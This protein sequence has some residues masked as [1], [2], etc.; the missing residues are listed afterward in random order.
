MDGRG[1]QAPAHPGPHGL[2]LGI[3]A[4]VVVSAEEEEGAARGH[5]HGGVAV[6]GTRSR[7]RPPRGCVAC[8]AH[9]HHRRRRGSP[10]AP[11]EAT[12]SEATHL[13]LS[14]RRIEAMVGWEG[15]GA[16]G[17]GR[18]G[19]LKPAARRMERVAPK[20]MGMGRWRPRGGHHV[21]LA[22]PRPI[23]EAPD[24]LGRMLHSSSSTSTSTTSTSTPKVDEVRRRGGPVERRRDASPASRERPHPG[25]L[26]SG[27]GGGGGRSTRGGGTTTTSGQLL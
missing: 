10:T 7:S 14:C 26:Q 27:Q 6:A 13:S 2:V 16:P 23:E 3:G 19:G 18:V 8:A 25:C 11:R 24:A 4:I 5:F 21:H 22:W 20:G 17:R 1:G 15:G 9:G 12:P